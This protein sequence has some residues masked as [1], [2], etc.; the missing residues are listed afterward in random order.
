[1]YYPFDKNTKLSWYMFICRKKDL[2]WSRALP[3]ATELDGPLI[4]CIVGK[5]NFPGFLFYLFL[6]CLMT[7]ACYSLSR[8]SSTAISSYIFHNRVV[9]HFQP[10]HSENQQL[11]PSIDQFQTYQRVIHEVLSKQTSCIMSISSLC[12]LYGIDT[13]STVVLQSENIESA[14]GS[15]TLYLLDTCCRLTYFAMGNIASHF[16]HS[17]VHFLVAPLLYAIRECCSVTKSISTDKTL[18][19]QDFYLIESLYRKKVFV[20]NCNQ[21]KYC[22]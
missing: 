6:F 12:E 2:G 16:Q 8:D 7:Y 3:Y 17:F 1:M 9:A 15:R 4:Y 19:A 10:L 22:A 5:I 14:L 21:L 13:K 18:S 20:Y 11:S